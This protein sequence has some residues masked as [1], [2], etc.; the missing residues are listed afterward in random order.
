MTTRGRLGDISHQLIK[1]SIG[2]P[3][4]CSLCCDAIGNAI[5]HEEAH[6]SQLFIFMY[7]EQY[8]DVPM[9]LLDE[10]RL[11]LRRIKRCTEALLY[12]CSGHDLH[13]SSVNIQ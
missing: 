3:T 5:E 12:I 6:A 13:I 4:L 10:H 9:L 7:R 8:G 1:G 11:T 2:K